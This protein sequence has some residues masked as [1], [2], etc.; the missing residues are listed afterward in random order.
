MSDRVP[1]LPYPAVTGVV[2]SL[3]VALV[4]LSVLTALRKWGGPSTQ[5]LT[6]RF[7]IAMVVVFAFLG[8]TAYG[9]VAA[10]PQSEQIGQLLGALISA[11]TII[12]T[13]FF[14]PSSRD[15]KDDDDQ[16]LR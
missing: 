10:I 1:I 15:K 2:T 14:G 4:L 8:V 6:P 7:V 11:F 3:L 5:F 13:Y 12:V 9:A 16:S